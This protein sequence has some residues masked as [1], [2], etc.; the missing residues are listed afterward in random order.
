MSDSDGYT[1]DPDRLRADS[2]KY[3]SRL[4]D[5]LEATRRRVRTAS[6]VSGAFSGEGDIF[7]GV[8]RPWM[9]ML[10]QLDNVLEQNKETIELDR[11]ALGAIAERYEAQEQTT[12]KILGQ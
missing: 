11:K 5:D 4:A 8:D 3:L 6:N 12:A 2:N 1:V 7:A 9:D 10:I